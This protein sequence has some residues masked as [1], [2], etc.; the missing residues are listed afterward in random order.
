MRLHMFGHSTPSARHEEAVMREFVRKLHTLAVIEHDDEE[1]ELPFEAHRRVSA[2]VR[3]RR[4]HKHHHLID[5][6]PCSG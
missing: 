3:F 6:N 5:D 2:H 4:C 1:R